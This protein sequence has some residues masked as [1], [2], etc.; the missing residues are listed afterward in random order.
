VEFFYAAYYS[1]FQLE[2]GEPNI[3]KTGIARAIEFVYFAC[4]YCSSQIH[5]TP[6]CDFRKPT[7]LSVLSLSGAK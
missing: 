1:P 3:T 2:Q 5:S 6:K 7:E 4:F